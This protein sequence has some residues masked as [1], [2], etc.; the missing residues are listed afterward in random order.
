MTEYEYYINKF[1]YLI[2]EFR[3]N[4]T[5]SWSRTGSKVENFEAS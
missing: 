5:F 2:L 1:H 4:P 3:F